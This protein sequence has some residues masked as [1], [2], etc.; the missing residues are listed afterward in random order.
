MRDH[1]RD[2]PAWAALAQARMTLDWA[3]QFFEPHA[4][5]AAAWLNW[6]PAGDPLRIERVLFAGNANHVG[7]GAMFRASGM[8]GPM[9]GFWLGIAEP[10]PVRLLSHQIPWPD[11][12]PASFHDGDDALKVGRLS[13]PEILDDIDRVVLLP[14]QDIQI[15]FA[16]AHTAASLRR[17]FQSGVSVCGIAASLTEAWV[18]R[19]LLAVFGLRVSTPRPTHL[20]VCQPGGAIPRP[21]TYTWRVEGSCPP[22][23]LAAYDRW[24]QLHAWLQ[25][26]NEGYPDEALW[27]GTPDPEG[28]YVYLLGG[29]CL[30]LQDGYIYRPAAS[31]ESADDGFE[32]IAGPV[33]RD[34]CSHP[35]QHE[36]E[37]A[38]RWYWALGILQSF[39]IEVGA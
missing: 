34:L 22:L 24:T 10:W 27:A 32:R 37:P 38:A 6:V 15:D 14:S 33:P 31:T 8:V 9:L 13:D 16:F 29:H 20:Q 11:H 23:A 30:S 21:A 17:A 2:S 25:D 39:D 4:A 3:S 28:D 18:V 26:P 1:L 36:T 35:P 7:F 12:L 19:D 5:I